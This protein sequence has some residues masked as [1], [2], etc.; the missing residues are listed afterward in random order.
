MY[1]SKHRARPYPVRGSPGTLLYL[2]TFCGLAASKSAQPTA[3]HNCIVLDRWVARVGGKGAT[4]EAHQSFVRMV[5]VENLAATARHRGLVRLVLRNKAT[6]DGDLGL[7]FYISS[8]HSRLA[9]GR[10][11]LEQRRA[12][13]CPSCGRPPIFDGTTWPTKTTQG[14]SISTIDTS[15]CSTESFDPS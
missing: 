4:E 7:E 6:P 10:C 8:S 13:G 11:H 14:L 15:Y 9:Q 5:R 3:R 1:V 2:A 12:Q